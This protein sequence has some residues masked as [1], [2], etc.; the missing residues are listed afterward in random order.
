MPAPALPAEIIW[1]IASGQKLATLQSLTLISRLFRLVCQQ[2]LFSKLSLNVI[3]VAAADRLKGI[4]TSP[5]IVSYIQELVLH[6]SGPTTQVPWHERLPE[7]LGMVHSA[8]RIKALT[9]GALDSSELGAMEDEYQ[10]AISAAFRRIC[11]SATLHT[12]EVHHDF[13]KYLHHCGPSLKHLK[14]V[15]EKGSP[16]AS[17]PSPPRRRSDIK[18]QSFTFVGGGSTPYTSNVFPYMLNPLN[19]ISFK[20]FK[21]LEFGE[22]RTV[23]DFDMANALLDRCRH[24][25]EDLDFRFKSRVSESDAVGFLRLQPLL[26]LKRFTFRGFFVWPFHQDDPNPYTWLIAQVSVQ[27]Q[28]FKRLRIII[29]EVKYDYIPIPSM[30]DRRPFTDWEELGEMLSNRELF[31]RLR[32]VKIVMG[33]A[34]SSKRVGRNGGGD[35]VMS[36]QE[37]VLAKKL[38]EAMPL[39]QAQGMLKIEKCS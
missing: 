34:D 5:R 2:V 21:R 9:L 24:S 23:E 13:H 3:S 36:A 32:L 25:L 16:N 33:W 12:L 1:K 10:E 20:V 17:P 26:R 15:S 8:G 6:R 28:P 30:V 29:L 31:P 7:F 4:M 22:C 19:K 18:L 11:A 27:G 38:E 39:L 14:V 37:V 35:S